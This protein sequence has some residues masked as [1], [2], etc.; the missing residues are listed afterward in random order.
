[1]R[2]VKSMVWETSLLDSEEGIRFRGLSIPEVQQK[3][4]KAKNGTEPLPEALLWLLITGEVPTEAQTQ[5]VSNDLAR[6][7]DQTKLGFVFDTIK[8]LAK[9]QVHPMS[10]LVAAVSAAQK[11]SIFAREYQQGVNKKE[12]WNSTFEDAMNLIA[13]LPYIASQIYRSR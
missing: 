6:R 12:Y 13:Q 4:P 10:Q 8:L 3:L 9:N 7:A 1:M 11:E 2:S 5:S